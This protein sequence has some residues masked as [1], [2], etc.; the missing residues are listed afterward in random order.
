MQSKVIETIARIWDVNKRA[1]VVLVSAVNQVTT[2]L[3]ATKSGQ[4]IKRHTSTYHQWIYSFK[5]K[6]KYQTK[7]ITVTTKVKIPIVTAPHLIGK[8]AQHEASLVNSLAQ[9]Q[10]QQQHGSNTGGE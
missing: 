3:A 2:K 9:T 5:N 10:T 7:R 8:H 6:K 1:L 4:R